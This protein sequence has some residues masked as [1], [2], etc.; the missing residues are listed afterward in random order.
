VSPD[1]ALAGAR[2]NFARRDLRAADATNELSD[3]YVRL[4]RKTE[5]LVKALSPEDMVVQSMPDASPAKWHLAH[6]TW[7]FEAFLLSIHSPGYRVF[8]P[9]YNFL[10]NSYYEALGP[11]QPRAQRGLLTRPSSTDVMAYR[12]YVDSHMRK[13]LQSSIAAETEDLARLGLAHEEQH[14]ELLL[15]DVLHLFSQ[16][17]TKPT[18]D[19]AWPVDAIGRKGQFKG[20]SGGPFELGATAASFA[21]DNERPRHTTWLRPF[22]ISDRLVTNGEWLAFM[23]DGG[24][25]RPELW[26]ADGWT[27]IQSESWNSPLYWVQTPGG[28]SQMSLRGMRPVDPDAP[29]TQVSYYE[30]AAYACWADARLPTE[31][32]WECAARAGLLEQV[33]EV[34]WQWTQSAY[35][36]YPGF[37]AAESA[38]GEYNGKFMV[39]QMVL[40]GGASVTPARHSRL[41]YRNFFR[42]EQRWMFSGVRLARD[43][44]QAGESCELTAAESAFA[45]DVIAGLSAWEKTL[46]PKYFYDAVGSELFEAI[47]R[48]PEYYPTRVE[49]ALL[50]QFALEITAGIPEG[51]VLVE[52]GSG[53]SAK[54]RV[55]LDAAPQIAAYVPIDISEDA[56]AKAAAVLSHDYPELLVVPVAEDFTDAIR[57]PA[58]A[59]VGVKVGFF[60]GSTIGNFTQTEALRFLRSAK[61]LLGDDSVLLIGADL[62]KDEATLVAAYD[63]VEG[64]T[65]RFNK[66]L[67]ARINRELGGNFD[68]DAFDHLAIWNAELARME[69]HLVSRADQIV[70]AARHTFAFKAGERLHTENSHKFTTKSFADLAAQAGWSV[71]REWISAAP[72]FAVFRLA[73]ES[74]NTFHV[75]GRKN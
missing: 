14:Q 2:S 57:L 55:I 59:H 72:Q 62:V 50:Q 46:P 53:A 70:N 25:A 71:R 61:Q 4:R 36:A 51:A 31:A 16:S 47:T 20:T 63:D 12:R 32:E 15:M 28:W 18:Y 60:P 35:S 40:R 5:S 56:L 17:P 13:L 64:I 8:D 42:P 24:Y 7:F 43:L 75:N 38:T 54:T 33:E 49:T 39:G 74:S 34:A 23:A 67:L 10:F 41:T 26:L 21:F 58:A 22:E 11:R 6:T 65:A 68:L 44:N 45:V 3:R 27:L 66:N 69:M 29:V 1:A 37:R 19:E 52:F 48:T 9:D 73:R 30:A